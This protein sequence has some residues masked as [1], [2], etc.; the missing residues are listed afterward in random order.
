MYELSFKIDVITPMFISGADNITPELRPPSIKGLL[1]FWWRAMQS[2]NANLRDDETE[3]FGS[4]TQRSKINIRLLKKKIY[5]EKKRHQNGLKYL[6]FS[7]D[8]QNRAYIKPNSQFVLRLTSSC[9]KALKKAGASFW[10][11]SY[12]GGLGSRSR[13]GAGNWAIREVWGEVSYELPPF[14][15]TTENNIASYITFIERGLDEIRRILKGRY[16]DNLPNYTALHPKYTKIYIVDEEFFTWQEA[17]EEIGKYFM[18]FRSGYQPDSQIISDLLEEGWIPKDKT[19]KRAAFGL[20][21][22]FRFRHLAGNVSINERRASPFI[23]RLIKIH[24]K[25]II[26]LLKMDSELLEKNEKLKLKGRGTT[27]L[28]PPKSSIIDEFI[29]ELKEHIILKE[30]KL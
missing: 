27:L 15:I 12:F 28:P 19:I 11:A 3:I 18:E 17:L 25:Y 22:T 23:I 16:S 24:K 10:L 1:R 7:M 20:P 6:F 4:T 30:I 9:K 5:T 8:M 29:I 21:L 14:V 26:L 2:G 13:R